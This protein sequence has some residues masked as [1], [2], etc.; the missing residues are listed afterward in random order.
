MPDRTPA[1]S[2]STGLDALIG[3]AGGVV[4]D[5]AGADVGASREAR[6]RRRW[7]KLAVVVYAVVAVLWLRAVT[8]S[9]SGFL[10]LPSIDPFLLTIIIFFGLLLG[11][12]VGQQVLSGRS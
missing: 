10:P 12:A 9:G 7:V 3:A 6:R 11:M 1:T 4:L 8:Y 5:M 2:P